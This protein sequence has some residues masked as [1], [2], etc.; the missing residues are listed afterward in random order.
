MGPRPPD[1]ANGTQLRHRPRFGHS[2]DK[3]HAHTC[4]T[5]PRQP[6][7]G[8][9]RSFPSAAIVNLEVSCLLFFRL[10]V[11]FVVG[12]LLKARRAFDGCV[13]RLKSRTFDGCVCCSHLSSPLPWAVTPLLH[14]VLTSLLV[15]Q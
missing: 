8:E 2:A 1:R 4:M 15:S 5:V 9:T 10:G 11:R 6:K 7:T 14:L 13:I 12:F 3:P